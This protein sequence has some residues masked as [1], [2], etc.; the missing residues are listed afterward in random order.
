MP[1]PTPT[2]SPLEAVAGTADPEV[3]A[4]FAV[5]SSET[6][7]SILL[8]LWEAYDPH[9]DETVSYS[10]L[11]DR[12]DYDDRGNFNYHLE[13]LKDHFIQKNPESGGYELVDTGLRVVQ[14]MVAGIETGNEA[15]E[16]T[17]IDHP[18]L[19]CGAPTR[20]GYRK[21]HVYWECTEC[22]GI[23]PDGGEIDGFLG[24]VKFEPSG[25]SGRTPEEIKAASQV[26]IL[27]QEASMF[28]G[29]CPTCSGPV[30]GRVDAC[31]DHDSNGVC[32][33][34][35]NRLS[36]RVRFRCRI[37]KDATTT[38]PMALA[39]SHPAVVAFYENHGVSMRFTVDDVESGKRIESLVDGH[40]LDVVSTDPVRVTVTVSYEGDEIALTF[41]ETA[42]VVDVHR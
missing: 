8:A 22:S 23:V 30:E 33:T 18:C 28:D 20:V 21:R 32:E 10:R 15:F 24:A 35:D 34:C 26:A 29:L 7:L 37:C 40:H 42:S 31:P 19:F 1:G 13:K 36:C 5:L 39:L 27:R 11:F 14:V 2:E 17:R 12:V 4:A 6:R 9:S 25:L 3:A 41:D 16:P 38:S